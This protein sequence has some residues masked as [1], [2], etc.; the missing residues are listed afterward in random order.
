MLPYT[1]LHH[2]LMARLHRPLVLTSGNGSDDP[3]AHT[4]DDAMARLGPLVD[5]IVTH[6]RPIHIRCDDSVVRARGGRIQVLR[7]SRGLAPEPFGLPFTARTQVLAV[8]AELKNTVVGAQR[9]GTA[10]PAI[11]SAISSIWP[12]ISHSSRP[13]TISADCSGSFPTWSPTTCTPSICP[14]RWRANSDLATVGVQ[15]HHA[16][17]A[18]CLVDHGALRPVLGV[19]FDGLGYGTDGT[20]LGRRVPRRRSRRLRA[21]RSPPGRRSPRWNRRDP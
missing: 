14:P 20:L 13:S 8:G 11:T 16:H 7:R 18:S 6:D 5:G 9:R 2:L 10:S 1:P 12:P 19:A 17:I 3:I 21:R 4:D 15:H